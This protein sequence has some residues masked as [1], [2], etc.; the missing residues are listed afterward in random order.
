MKITMPKLLVMTREYNKAKIS[1][2]WKFEAKLEYVKFVNA[3]T[4][5]GILDKFLFREIIANNNYM[6]PTLIAL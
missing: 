2:L 6:L 5:V 4:Q 3:K 1:F